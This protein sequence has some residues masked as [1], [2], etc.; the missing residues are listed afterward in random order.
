[1]RHTTSFDLLPL[2]T[3]YSCNRFLAPKVAVRTTA[4]GYTLHSIRPT[5][6]RLSAAASGAALLAHQVRKPKPLKKLKPVQPAIA[7]R[8]VAEIFQ[9]P[10][11]QHVERKPTPWIH[12]I[13]NLAYM[14]DSVVLLQEPRRHPQTPTDPV[15]LC[16]MAFCCPGGTTLSFAHTLKR[17]RSLQLLAVGVGFTFDEPVPK[18]PRLDELPGGD[19]RLPPTP[20]PAPALPDVTSHPLASVPQP[21]APPS[22][23]PAPPPPP[24]APPAHPTPSPPTTLAQPTSPPFDPL[25]QHSQSREAIEECSYSL[26]GDSDFEPESVNEVAP[27]A[28]LESVETKTWRGEDMD[29]I[30]YTFWVSSSLSQ[31]LLLVA[32]ATRLF[33]KERKCA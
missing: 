27:V 28:S 11:L 32:L 18:R 4:Q 16:S 2:R 20:C 30:E 13:Y 12:P 29:L 31:Y 17:K 5:H 23:P 10:E 33:T 19:E 9:H 15:P 26:A 22:P 7:S 25:N 6:Q 8:Q 14:G 3:I 1:M 24:P 21:P